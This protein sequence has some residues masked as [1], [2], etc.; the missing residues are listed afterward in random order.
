MS[1][2]LFDRIQLLRDAGN[3]VSV[4][5]LF[6]FIAICSRLKLLIRFKLWGGGYGESESIHVEHAPL[7]RLSTA[8]LQ[9][10]QADDELYPMLGSQVDNESRLVRVE[11]QYLERVV[12]LLRERG[13]LVD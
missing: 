7:L 6:A 3:R 10:L 9:D 4:S 2:P 1:V 8:I 12:S 13:F 5:Q 11:A